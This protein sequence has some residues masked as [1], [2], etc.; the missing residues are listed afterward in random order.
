[1]LR[2]LEQIFDKDTNVYIDYANVLHWQDKLRWHIETKRLKQFFDSFT[3]IK[4]VKLYFGTLVGD[5]RSEQQIY[6]V[7]SQG[8][9][10]RTKPVK[11]MHFSIDVSSIPP[12]SPALLQSFIKKCLLSKLDLGTITF[13][14]QKL[15]GLNQ[16]G[17]L[18]IEDKKCNFDVEIGRDMMLDEHGN[19][20]DNFILW[21]GDSDFAEPV[22]LLLNNGKKAV[23]FATSGKV[24][25]ELANSGSRIFDIKKIKEFI[26]FSREIPQDIKE[27]I[28]F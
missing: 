15:K 10:V 4:E 20:T 27:K 8:Y 6:E 14:N 21:S 16:Q 2:E 24:S 28:T 19:A 18:Y 17:Q 5:Q 1:V 9:D 22:K 23:L 3:T 13:L 25:I 11:I 7:R 26:C 12:D